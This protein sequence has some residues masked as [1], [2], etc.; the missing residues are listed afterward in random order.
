METYTVIRRGESIQHCI[1]IPPE[2][3]DQELEITI[4]PTIKKGGFKKKLA[5][6]FE[7]NKDIQPFKSIIDPVVW[8]KEQRSDWS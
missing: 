7:K 8:E 4:K 2:F 3:V 5:L 6:L 1:S